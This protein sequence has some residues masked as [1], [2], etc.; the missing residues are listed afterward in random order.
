MKNLMKFWVVLFALVMTSCA[1]EDITTTYDSAE[2]RS[3]ISGAPTFDGQSYYYYNSPKPSPMKIVVTGDG[4]TAAEYNNGLFDQKVD[5]MMAAFFSYEPYKTYKEYIEVYK[6]VAH[7]NVSG[8][9]S[10]PR[11]TKFGSFASTNT[12]IDHNS[13]INILSA[14]N[15]IYQFVMDHVPGIDQSNIDDVYVIVLCNANLDAGGCW[16]TTYQE[17]RGITILGMGPNFEAVNIHE[18]GH[19]IG[20]L[21]DEYA[22]QGLPWVPPGYPI[23]P[24]PTPMPQPLVT[25]METN[26]NG[27]PWNHYPNLHPYNDSITA[28]WAKYYNMPNY[29]N[30][31][32]FEGGNDWIKGCWRST[33]FSI[34]NR[35]IDHASYGFN[36][37]SREAI[38]RRLL[39][40]ADETFDFQTFL[41]NDSNEVPVL[42]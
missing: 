20:R 14:S 22:S 16:R 37:I 42:L 25:L 40:V 1:Y 4:F 32:F 39:D 24:E 41:A 6:L 36:V 12:F 30:V 9:T 18:S 34:M 2:S 31:D 38:V 17:G 10:Q 29:D 13:S 26:R 7:S 8:I 11:D 33:E 5:E 3:A 15:Q 27:N 35:G 21:G 23:I 28:L 19:G